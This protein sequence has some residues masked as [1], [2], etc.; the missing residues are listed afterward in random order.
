M[1]QLLKEWDLVYGSPS[2]LF[3]ADACA[4]VANLVYG[5]N[6]SRLSIATSKNV[7]VPQCDLHQCLHP[8][9]GRLAKRLK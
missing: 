4:A 5:M 7:F 1:V 3:G 2:L 6:T 8:H 9:K